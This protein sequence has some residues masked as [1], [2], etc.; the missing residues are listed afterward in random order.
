MDESEFETETTEFV[1]IIGDVLECSLLFRAL[2]QFESLSNS[3]K[4]QTNELSW[5][6]DLGIVITVNRLKI[7]RLIVSHCGIATFN[8]L[9]LAF[10]Q[11]Q[12]VNISFNNV[13]ELDCLSTAVNI[14]FLD[15]SHNR[16]SSLS[17]LSALNNLNV[18]RCHNNIVES[19]EDVKSCTQLQE[20]WVSN[21]RI[22][23]QQFVHLS[24]LKVLEVL[25]KGDREK[26]TEESKKL[27]TFLINIVP[28]L[29][30]LDGSP[31]SG[32]ADQGLSV[33]VKIMLTQARAALNACET[34]DNRI[35]SKAS[36]TRKKPQLPNRISKKGSRGSRLNEDSSAGEESETAPSSRGAEGDTEGD[37]IRSNGLAREVTSEPI[38]AS[39]RAPG[40]AS[41]THGRSTMAASR[42][43]PSRKYPPS[44]AASSSAAASAVRRD[45]ESTSEL[46]QE[47]EEE[48]HKEEGGGK[49]QSLVP[50]TVVRFPSS[51]S[52]A[53]IA[54]CIYAN[55]DGYAR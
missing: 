52:D 39:E 44:A 36:A 9:A 55:K 25:I 45:N 7:T 34:A 40:G 18:L 13:K 12:D 37:A 54:L 30:I 8:S 11:V 49:G 17:F 22:P 21:N 3:S 4:S 20:L 47:E 53:P 24:S 26:S 31:V 5:N 14:R 2:S 29:R 23:W 28:S 15:I 38:V 10:S 51:T 27:D 42:K 6:H 33:D 1:S 32:M 16:I 41:A 35:S 43:I 48:Q 46:G 50:E 19:L